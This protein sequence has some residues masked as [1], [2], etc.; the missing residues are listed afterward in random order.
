MDL[1][2]PS[3]LVRDARSLY[4]STNGLADDGGYSDERVEIKFGRLPISI[5]N[6]PAR[7]RSV[8]LH[9]LHHIATGYHT[10]LAGESEIGAWE[11]AI[12]CADHPAAWVLNLL[13][14]SYG[15][16]LCPRRLFRAFLRGHGTSNLYRQ[17]FS[18]DLLQQTVADLRANLHVR[19]SA[20]QVTLSGLAAFFFWEVVAVGLGLSVAAAVLSPL[21]VIYWITG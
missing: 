1:Y 13:A 21:A 9:D 12:G 4:F 7:V 11:V 16:L 3:L 20:P 14:M 19:D 17:E 10:D 6:S 2:D 15:L 18:E 8:R 5:P